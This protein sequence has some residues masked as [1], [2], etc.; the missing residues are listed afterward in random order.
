MALGST[1]YVDPGAYQQEVVVPTGLNIANQPFAVCLIGTGSRNK[2]VTNEPVLRGITKSEVIVPAGSSPHIVALANRGDRRTADTTVYKTLNGITTIVPDQYVSFDPAYVLGTVTGTVDLS[3]SANNA[4]AIEM[5]GLVPLTLVLVYNASSS[6]TAKGHEITVNYPFSGTGG[7]AATMTDIAAAVNL[8]LSSSP[9]AAFSYGAAYANVASTSAGALMITSPLGTP[10]S[11]VEVFAPDADSGL[12]AIFGAAGS[13]NRKAQTYI[14]ISD[15]IWS[16]GATWKVDYVNIDATSDPLAQTTNIQDIVRVGSQ[17]G[18]SNFNVASDYQL[19]SNQVDWTPPTAAP[20]TG[21]GGT[22]GSAPAKTFDI[23]VNNMLVV[24]FDGVTSAYNAQPV[25]T[26]VLIQLTGLASPPIGYAN[27]GTPT[28]ATVPEIVN[29]INAVLAAALG[30]QYATAA[31]LVTVNGVNRV[32]LTSPVKGSAQSAIYV[33]AAATNSAHTI[34]FGGVASSMGTGKSP[35]PGTSYYVTYDYTRA[36]TEYNVP[37]QSFSVDAALAQVGAP[38][39]VT[40]AFNPLAIASQLAFLNGAQFIY[41]VQIN[42]T[43]AGNPTRSQVFD[44]MQGAETLAGT[45]EMI[46]IG[47]PGNRLDVITDLISVLETRCSLTEKQPCRIWSGMASNTAIGDS[48]TPNTLVYQSARVL[49]VGPNSPGRGRMFNIAPPQQQ[50]VSRDVGMPDGSTV[51]LKLDSSYLAVAWAALRTT[52]NPADTLSFRS[53]LGFNT[54]DITNFW[55]PAERRFMAGQGTFVTTFDAGK[56]KVLDAISTETGP[57]TG[58]VQFSVD[59]T[60]YQ[61]DVVVTNVTKALEQNIVGIVPFDLATF[62]LDIKL[63]IQG[64]ISSS[65]SN[66]VIGP[67]R[68]SA[69]NIRP[70]DLRADIKVVQNVNTPTEFDFAYWFNLRYPALRLFGTYTV[71]S[72][73]LGLSSAV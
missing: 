1:T 33:K 12:I 58:L 22:G 3:S 23:S 51:R 8:G 7:N 50:G 67:F 25:P 69:G 28:A 45:T 43:A 26:D 71:D 20:L 68:D 70:I 54:D 47:E 15:L 38:D 9:A 59:S 49:Q 52:L 31:S 2:R 30:P 10:Q 32:K 16:A 24:G 4:F 44:A 18:G 53:I 65:I 41:T 5:D 13:G 62:I 29:N 21:V 39:P 40:P 14:H 19:T 55:K 72:P 34:L 56:L 73:F 61:K 60:S 42:D 36:V 46:V 17:Q 64:A 37:Y 63:V 6:V 27:A 48:D 11:D 35:T 57:G 66:Q